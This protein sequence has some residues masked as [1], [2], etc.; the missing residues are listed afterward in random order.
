[1]P[2]L[3]SDRSLRLGLDASGRVGNARQS[4]PAPTHDGLDP[5]EEL[6]GHWFVSAPYEA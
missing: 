5:E 4:A 3:A 2:K 6:A 1:M